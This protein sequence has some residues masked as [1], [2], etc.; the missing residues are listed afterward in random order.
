[1]VD[2]EREGVVFARV[3][4]LRGSGPTPKLVTEPPP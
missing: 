1:M 4:D 3:Y 2:I